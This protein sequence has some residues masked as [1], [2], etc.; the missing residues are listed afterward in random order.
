MRKAE[1]LN[2][3]AGLPVDVDPVKAVRPVPYKAIP[4]SRYGH[5]SGIRLDGTREFIDACLGRL[6]SMLACENHGTRLEVSYR[7][8]TDKDTGLPMED[9]YACYIRVVRRGR[10]AAPGLANPGLLQFCAKAA[11]AS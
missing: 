4:G 2:H 3:W 10:Q 7:Q 1:L 11:K 8:A 5:Y 6:K 9:A